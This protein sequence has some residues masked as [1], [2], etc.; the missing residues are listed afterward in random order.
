VAET[1]E[2]TAETAEGGT[3]AAGVATLRPVR[4]PAPQPT[5]PRVVSPVRVPS[6]EWGV[7][8]EANPSYVGPEMPTDVKFVVAAMILVG[9]VVAIIV[10]VIVSNVIAAIII[11]VVALVAL[12]FFL[13][14]SRH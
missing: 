1:A 10:G 9:I 12:A 2:E 8:K 6:K 14:L 7:S 13:W 4:T 5:G 3:S 11:A